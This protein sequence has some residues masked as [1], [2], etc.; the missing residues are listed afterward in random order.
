MMNQQM[1]EI[2]YNISKMPLGKL[3]KDSIK[4]G[5]EILKKLSDEVKK[6]SPNRREI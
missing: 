4:L 2:G 1:K 3:S 6:K 5:F